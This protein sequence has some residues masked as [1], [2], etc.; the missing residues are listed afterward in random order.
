MTTDHKSAFAEQ[1]EII[2]DLAE[3]KNEPTIELLAGNLHGML[4]DGSMK[5]VDPTDSVPPPEQLQDRTERWMAKVF[6]PG[7]RSDRTER[8]DRLIEEVF[9]LAQALDYDFD[10][11]PKLSTYVGGRTKGQ[12]GAEVGGVANCLFAL[13]NAINVSFERAYSYEMDRIETPEMMAK[14]RAKW[15][16]KPTDIKSP[17]PGKSP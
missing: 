5:I 15:E 16:S 10:R 14:V 1:L 3:R 9:E 7:V 4:R 12:P 6:P 2:C 17:L 11:I 13:C 8:L